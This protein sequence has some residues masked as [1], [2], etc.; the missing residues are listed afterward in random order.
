MVVGENIL[1]F[2]F[3]FLGATGHGCS[4]EGTDAA[5]R[6]HGTRALQASQSYVRTTVAVRPYRRRR[7]RRGGSGGGG[8]LPQHSHWVPPGFDVGLDVLK[9]QTNVEQH[10]KP[11]PN[12]S[13]TLM[14]DSGFACCSTLVCV[15]P[16][17]SEGRVVR[18]I[19][20]IQS[21]LLLLPQSNCFLPQTVL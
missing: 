2:L 3:L 13:V 10:A 15:F 18:F 9:T 21:R 4:A 5:P 17:A 7:K 8:S 20:C 6:A 1:E 11:E 16:L 19:I 12:M 14:L